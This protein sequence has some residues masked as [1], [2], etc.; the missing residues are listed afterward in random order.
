LVEKYS[1]DVFGAVTIRDASDQILTTSNFGNCRMFTG[2]EYDTE[3]S[4]Y[5]YRARYYKPSIGRFLQTDPIGYSGGINLYAYCSNNPL[6][7]RDPWGLCK[8][9]G[10][11]FQGFGED[12]LQAFWDAVN[13]AS[14]AMSAH[15]FEGTG[16]PGWVD[17]APAM[18]RQGTAGQIT[19]VL[20]YISGASAAAAIALE[21]LGL[22]IV[23]WGTGAG[24]AANNLSGRGGIGPVQIGQAGERAVGLS[25]P[26]KAIMHGGR[27]LFPD[28]VTKTT[29]TEVKNVAT[30]SFTKQLRNYLA[31]AQQNGLKFELYTRSTTQLSGPLDAAR[32][33]GTIIIKPIP[34]M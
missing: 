5:Y 6:R 13:I 11:Q 25:G 34:G 31:Y 9:D 16:M 33:N 10:G 4:L 12:L 22:D 1:Y 14:N 23:L 26:K 7:W 24:E 21:A 8:K 2:R 27:K 29:L 17:S 32:S 20:G 28:Q 3:T 30:Q 15:M 18:A 19:R